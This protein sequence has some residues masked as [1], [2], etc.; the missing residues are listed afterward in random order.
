MNLRKISIFFGCIISYAHTASTELSL[1]T[2]ANR[3]HPITTAS[4][5]ECDLKVGINKS[6]YAYCYNSRFNENACYSYNAYCTWG[7]PPN[8]FDAT[9][10][11][12]VG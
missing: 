5:Y 3:L 10:H 7:P 12:K 9:C 4:N 1:A 2:G 8:D 6:F 11:L